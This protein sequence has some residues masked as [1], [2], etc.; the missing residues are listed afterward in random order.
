[1]ETFKLIPLKYRKINKPKISEKEK[2]FLQTEFLLK[3]RSAVKEFLLYDEKLLD[4]DIIK[5]ET[6][7]NIKN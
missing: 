1:M 2:I 5:L 7:Q 6:S 4:D 3:G